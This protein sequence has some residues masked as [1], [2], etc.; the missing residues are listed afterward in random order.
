MALSGTIYGSTN[1]QWIDAKIEWSATQSIANNTSTITAKLYYIR[2]NTGYTTHGNLRGSIT[3]DGDTTSSVKE[4]WITENE[5]EEAATAKETVSHNSD[6]TK[7]L[8]ISAT[9]YINNTSLDSTS[10]SGTITLDT[11]HRKAAIVSAPN[12]N[13]E[14]NPTIT[15]ENPAGNSIT[16]LQACISLT[17]A[18]DDVAYRNISKTG[19]SYTFNL[20]AAER[21]TL[22]RATTGKS[23]TV[24]FYV[25]SVIGGVETLTYIQRTFTITNAAPTINPT[26][27]DTNGTT[28]VLTGDETKLIRYYSNAFITTGATPLKYATLKSQ[29]VSN[30][31]KSLSGN[32]T[33]NAVESGTFVFSAT[34]SRGFTTTKTVNIPIV[35]YIKLT[36]DVGNNMPDTDGNYNLE[37]TGN[38]FNGSFGAEN[39]ILKV[40]MRYKVADGDFSNWMALTP[41]IT[42]NTYYA[43]A[44]INGLDYQT[45]YTF[46]AYAIDRL[47]T[48]YSVEKAVKSTPIFDWG[49]DDFNVNGSFGLRGKTVLRN[50]GDNNNIVLS[51]TDA[52]DGVF[53]R[54]NGTGSNEGQTIFKK[55]G[56]ITVNGGITATGSITTNGI[57]IGQNKVLWSGSYLMTAGHT[58]TLSEAVS[59]QATGIVLVFSQYND[60]SGTTANSNFSC[61][62]VPKQIVALH[63]GASFSYMMS[64]VNF[65]EVACKVLYIGNTE[66]RGHD[67]NGEIIVF[68]GTTDINYNNG[69]YVLRY[70]IGV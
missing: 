40:Y 20:T 22:L 27:I 18:A 13:D 34:D 30:G 50:N 70:V 66:I 42:G 67:L 2:T 3:I 25:K 55:N 60:D 54:P 32:G 41:S 59:E 63:G 5:W 31:S 69:S 1:N 7:S 38:Y 46:Q 8:T 57:T 33:I 16:T 45:T 14:E 52:T 37:I 24:R 28:K 53:I 10:I 68:D 62:F 12:F 47:A 9:G 29:K 11:I 65:S 43:G 23:R 21:N 4:I 36:C 15:Y 39:N 51:A 26:I 6:G 64:R 61:H 58:I 48:V 19:T 35:N 44:T 49:K 17:G 56:D